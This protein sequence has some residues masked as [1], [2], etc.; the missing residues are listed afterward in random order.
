MRPFLQS[1][2]K[3]HHLATVGRLI[4]HLLLLLHLRLVLLVV[5]EGQHF[6]VLLLQALHVHQ[7]GLGV[8]AQGFFLLLYFF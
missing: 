6:R 3:L 4:K 2:V 1:D 7:V 5:Q 8:I